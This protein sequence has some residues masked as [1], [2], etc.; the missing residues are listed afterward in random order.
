MYRIDFEEE[1][2]CPYCDKKQDNCELEVNNK[3]GIE[4]QIVSC[5]QCDRA[6]AVDGHVEPELDFHKIEGQELSV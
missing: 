3:G 4:I 1:I 6:F 5:M 2:A